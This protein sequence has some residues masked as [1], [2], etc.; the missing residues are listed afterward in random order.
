MPSVISVDIGQNSQLWKLRWN[1]RV[2]GRDA[3]WSPFD[4]RTGTAG[5][6]DRRLRRW[7]GRGG[8]GRASRASTARRARRTA[9]TRSR[10]RRRCGVG[11]DEKLRWLPSWPNIAIEVPSTPPIGTNTIAPVMPVLASPNKH[12]ASAAP[13]PSSSSQLR[14][15]RDSN[16]PAARSS[17]RKP[18]NAGDIA[19][20]IAQSGAGCE[21]A[22]SRNGQN[23]YSFAH[24]PRP[25]EDDRRR[26]PRNRRADH[27]RGE[28]P[29]RHDPPDPV[30]ELRLAA[31][32]SRRPARCSRTSTARAT[33]ASATTRASST[34]TRS[35]SS[36]SIARRRCSAPTTRTSQP[37]SGSPANLAVYFAFLKPG[38][39]VMGLALPMGGHLTHGWNV[40]ITGTYFKSRAVRRAQGHRTAS[41]STRSASSRARSARSCCGAAA[42]RIPRTIDFAAFG[43]DRAGG[44]RAASAPTSRTSPGLVAGGAHPSPVPH[45]RRRHRRRRTRR[46]AARAAA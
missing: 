36:A 3:S 17:A 14:A 25:R 33:R 21:S 8:G 34:S 38:D 41:T 24:A 30:G 35:S 46:C 28:A 29:A 16:M 20:N 1:Q 42:P 4:E 43:D 26:R 15:S 11:D 6:R 7:G 45:R 32:C 22:P 44:R 39:T 9:G 5:Y 23:W 27:R 2:F 40:S 12:A 31:P 19:R 37:Y 18:L 13:S 10:Q